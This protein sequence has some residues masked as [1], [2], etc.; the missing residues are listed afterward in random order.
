METNKAKVLLDD[1]QIPIVEK[2]KDIDY[3]IN[4]DSENIACI[5]DMDAANA[6]QYKL[7]QFILYVDQNL[8]LVKAQLREFEED[9]SNALAIEASRVTPKSLSLTEKRAI[10]LESNESL[11][12]LHAEVKELKMKEE[13]LNNMGNNVKNLLDVVKQVYFRLRLRD[14]G[15]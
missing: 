6:V 5:N 11:K 8:S 3:F 14:Y 13:L 4:T 15:S 7:S 9:Y 2:P 10:A 12:S 1:M